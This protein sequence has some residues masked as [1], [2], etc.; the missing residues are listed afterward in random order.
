MNLD[1]LCTSHISLLF[2]QLTRRRHGVAGPSHLRL[3]R[4]RRHLG[5][6]SA[7][8]GVFRT[9]RA[10]LP[11]R[12]CVDPGAPDRQ[13]SRIDRGR[14]RTC[15][16]RT[17]QLHAAGAVNAPHPHEHG[18]LPAA[19]RH[20]CRAPHHGCRALAVARGGIRGGRR[21]RRAGSG[22]GGAG[23]AEAVGVRR[24]DRVDAPGAHIA[25]AARRSADQ[26]PRAGRP[27]HRGDSGRTAERSGI[28]SPG[29]GITS[30]GAGI[31]SPRATAVASPRV[32]TEGARL[33]AA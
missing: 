5:N 6:K 7:L 11:L 4:T 25:V 8:A 10:P 9:D 12:S 17:V 1:V 14:R 29:A 27:G 20:R 2:V 18:L 22:R 23:R 30:P 31:T 33:P 3:Y 24:S 16:P 32:G 15:G 26:D 19:T 13:Q 21:R 28:T